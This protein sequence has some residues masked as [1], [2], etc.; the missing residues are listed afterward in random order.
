MPRTLLNSS[1]LH[2]AGYQE[3]CG[4]EIEF[5]DGSVY[6]YADV[7]LQVYLALLRAESKGRFFNSHIRTQ[8]PSIRIKPAD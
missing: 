1:S 6:R 7:S 5:R 4:L 8:F 2:S 3:Q